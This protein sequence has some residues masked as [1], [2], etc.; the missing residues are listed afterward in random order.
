MPR[1]AVVK[2]RQTKHVLNEKRLLLELRHPFI[3]RLMA[4]FKDAERLML[5]MEFIAGGELY[6][7]L[8]QM[9]QLD[10]PCARDSTPPPPPATPQPQGRPGAGRVA[11]GRRA[12]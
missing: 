7:R 3:V 4:T 12:S 8:L 2:A 9:G 1:A 11:A 5:A 10:E 6:N